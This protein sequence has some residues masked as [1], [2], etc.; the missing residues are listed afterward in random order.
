MKFFKNILVI[1]LVF[2][3]VSLCLA[4][5]RWVWEDEEEVKQLDEGDQDQ[6]YYQNYRSDEVMASEKKTNDEK[7]GDKNLIRKWLNDRVHHSCPKDLPIS[8]CG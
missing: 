6:K 4:K 5:P 7:M 1:L 8:L 3:T 2:S